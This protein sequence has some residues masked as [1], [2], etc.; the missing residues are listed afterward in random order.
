[1]SSNAKTEI[2]ERL[3]A[4]RDEAHG[5]SY[6]VMYRFLVNELGADGTATDEAIRRWH[7]TG[8][9]PAQAPIEQLRVLCQFYSQALERPITLVDV[10]PTLAGRWANTR[11]I[12]ATSRYART[13]DPDQAVLFDAVA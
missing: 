7:T 2:A 13:V 3:R 4:L 11:R 8:I 12:A 5:P 6:G 1:M 9:E 10:H